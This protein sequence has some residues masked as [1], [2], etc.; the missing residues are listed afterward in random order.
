[1]SME[2]VST[3]NAVIFWN[4]FAKSLEWKNIWS[5]PYK[6]SLTNKVREISSK[7]IHRCYLVNQF[8][9]FRAQSLSEPDTL[10]DFNRYHKQQE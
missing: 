7:I 5:L 10:F 6:H 9:L 4:Q 3:A 2:T 8:L 1:M